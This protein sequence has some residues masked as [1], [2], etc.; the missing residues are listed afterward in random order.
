MPLLEFR[1]LEEQQAVRVRVINIRFYLQC[2]TP[3]FLR[4]TLD[5]LQVQVIYCKHYLCSWRFIMELLVA[6]RAEE[7]V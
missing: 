1:L 2:F 7:S 5:K 3:L 6:Y 4:I